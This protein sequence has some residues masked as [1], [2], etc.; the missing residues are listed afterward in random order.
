MDISLKLKGILIF[1]EISP[2]TWKQMFTNFS[3]KQNIPVK[4]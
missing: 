1:H 4:K 2:S 3:I